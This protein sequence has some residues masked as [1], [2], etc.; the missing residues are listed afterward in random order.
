M[1]FNSPDDYDEFSADALRDADNL[2]TEDPEAEFLAENLT[3]TWMDQE[4]HALDVTSC[5]LR[6]V[7]KHAALVSHEEF[8]VLFEQ[9]KAG[10]AEAHNALIVANLRLVVAIAK[11]YP[12]RGMEMSDMIQLGVLGVMRA[13][14]KFNPAKGHRFSTYA[15]LWIR[16][17]IERAM[18]KQT[19]TINVPVNVIRLASRV[20]KLMATLETEGTSTAS[21]AERCCEQLNL[22]RETFDSLKTVLKGSLHLDYYA[23]SDQDTPERSGAFLLDCQEHVE[24]S[25]DPET[26]Y[27]EQ[28]RKALLH[29]ALNQ[30]SRTQAHLLRQR[31]G[32]GYAEPVTLKEIANMAGISTEAIRQQ[33]VQA[34]AALKRVLVGKK[35]PTPWNSTL[36]Q[37]STQTEDEFS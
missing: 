28:E 34:L 32:I 12:D 29:D 31:F 17:H 23:E 1:Q 20:S 8:L 14:H 21:V 2:L 22:T 13:L 27:E 3:D 37:V 10:S 35:L 15:T 9:Y 11:R 24:H 33:Q 25:P 5:F 6:D 16:E 4:A 30:L 36:A 7:W 26:V 19:R 18:M